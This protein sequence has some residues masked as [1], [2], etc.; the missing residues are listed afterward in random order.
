[1]NQLF[2]FLE[3]TKELSNYSLVLFVAHVHQIFWLDDQL[4]IKGHHS[5][6]KMISKNKAYA[7]QD[8]SCVLAIERATGISFDHFFFPSPVNS[9]YG[10]NLPVTRDVIDEGHVNIMWLGRL[11]YDKVHSLVNLL[12]NLMD[13]PCSGATLHIIG[14][15]NSLSLID[16]NKYTPKITIV[17]NSIM[18]GEERNTYMRENADLVVAMGISS[19]D[20]SI[21]GIPTFLPLVSRGKFRDDRFTL[22][23]EAPEYS[24]GFEKE[25]C[26]LNGVKTNTLAEV[27]NLIY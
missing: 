3:D 21:E 1:M 7:M 24:L 19:L 17:F 26:L 20:A 6:Y 25:D 18:F 13:I 5:F 22:I 10:L 8:L 11:D 14:D 2:N 16:L 15:G 9:H 12:D 4:L 27:I 23:S